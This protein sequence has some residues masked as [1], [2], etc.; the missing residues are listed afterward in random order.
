M[1]HAPLEGWLSQFFG[2]TDCRR[3]EWLTI[4]VIYT[5]DI[6]NYLFQP[7]NPFEATR[8]AVYSQSVLSL[9]AIRGGDQIASHWFVMLRINE[10]DLNEREPQ[11]V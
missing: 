3:V 11:L 1:Q 10:R 7:D 5:G 8:A 6:V 4:A 9:D 2:I